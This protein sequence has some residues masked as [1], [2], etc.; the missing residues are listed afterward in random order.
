MQSTLKKNKKPI[1]LIFIA[2]YLPGFKYGGILVTVSN[3]IDYLNKEFEFKIITRDRDL[4]SRKPYEGI[5]YDEWQ[6]VGNAKVRYLKPKDINFKYLISLIRDTDYDLIQLNSFFDSIFT[7][8][9]VLAKKLKLVSDKPM[10]IAPRGELM[11]GDFNK[12]FLKK[13]LFVKLALFTGFYDKLIWQA[14]NKLE[15]QSFKKIM[16]V[17]SDSVSIALD[18]PTKKYL[19]KISNK[20]PVRLIKSDKLKIVFLN[21]LTR[22]K[23]LDYA[24]KII[25]RLG[26]N[27]IFDIYGPKQDKKYWSE[28]EDIIKGV[29][30]ITE[31]AYKG[32]LPP[33]KVIETFS[34]YDL[35]LHP[36][37][38][39]NYGHT[40][41]ESLIAGTPVLISKGTTQWDK[42]ED[43]G[44][45]WVASLSDIDLFVKKIK[46][47][48]NEDFEIR[49]KRR[50]IICS[51]IK[52]FLINPDI[53]KQNIDIFQKQL[54]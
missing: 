48:M 46:R 49:F 53:L 52:D 35:F 42:I 32:S 39:E 34:G 13:F 15:S 12:K 54:V 30:K 6:N 9:V 44:M 2:N 43:E 24:L 17:K 10:I 7:L 45:G 11:E 23:N 37:K 14:S 29:D 27:V 28:C 19:N 50:E 3:T 16:N 18:L 38:V 5:I 8:K 33:N 51:K 26:E 22:E 25:K 41:V 31:I 47:L 21:R 1:I 20:K 40:I 36:T 4:N